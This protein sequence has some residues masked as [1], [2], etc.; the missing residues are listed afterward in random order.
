[1]NPNTLQN[2]LL[3]A[4]L[5]AQP[6]DSLDS[7]PDERRYLA[8]LDGTQPLSVEEKRQL[9]LSPAARVRFFNARA[10]R[11]AEVAVAW[12]RQG[13][14]NT[15]QRLA[16]DGGNTDIARVRTADFT[17]T[18]QRDDTDPAKPEWIMILKLEGE[19][20]QS[21]ENGGFAVTVIDSG[22]L[23]WF[24]GTPDQDGTVSTVWSHLKSPLDRLRDHSITV[25]PC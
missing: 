12:K 6:W 24:H 14:Q 3:V 13:L 18:L 20:R 5:D 7:V 1:M 25:K 9:W 4:T 16:A 10:L 11:L 2:A 23:E 21:L 17:L 22:G 8:A 19:L 15:G